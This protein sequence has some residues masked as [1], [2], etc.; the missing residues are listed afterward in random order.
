MES[1]KRTLA[2]LHIIYGGLTLSVAII[3]N[4]I[5]RSVLP[6]I[7][8][9][10]NSEEVMFFSTFGHVIQS[11]VIFLLLLIP[12]PSVIGGIALLNG[13]KWGLTLILISGSLS[14]LSFPIGMALGAYTIWVFVKSGQEK[15]LNDQNQG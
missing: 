6:F 4:T 8:A 14:L 5:F 13:K 3:A 7:A 9:E 2:I 12:L 1:H 15:A 10:M 11:V